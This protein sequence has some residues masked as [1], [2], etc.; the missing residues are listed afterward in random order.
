MEH[1]PWIG[2]EYENGGGLGGQKIAV[3]GHS[4]YSD[5]LDFPSFTKDLI[6][7]CI[8]GPS[9]DF[10]GDMASFNVVPNYFG[11]QD[12][13]LFWSKVIFFNFLPTIV[14]RASQKF[15]AGTPGQIQAG[16]ARLLR[17]LNQE[18]PSKVFVFSKEAWDYCPKI[19]EAEEQD[20][21]R[22]LGS[23]FEGYT[24]GHYG[25]IEHPIATFGLR[26]PLGAKKERMQRV[27]K[28]LMDLPVETWCDDPVFQRDREP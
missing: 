26:H 10:D 7:S 6:E 2:A 4:H 20:L 25:S 1:E 17:I 24:M 5:N 27:V 16:T 11:F 13:R 8:S 21:S 28:T 23:D 15:E 19:L 12:R 22:R 3:V 14:G 9:E 18:R